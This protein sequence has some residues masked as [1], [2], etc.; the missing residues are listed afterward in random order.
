VRHLLAA[1][2]LLTLV[3][4]RGTQ[5]EAPVKPVGPTAEIKAPLGLPPVPIPVDNPPTA[6]TIALGRVLYFDKKLSGD[7]S[8]ACA[9]CHRPDKG[10]TDNLQFSVGV[11]GKF[12]GRNA[13]TV[14][15]AAYNPEQFWDG[16]AANLELQAEGPIANE[17]EMRLPHK[18][19]VK[20]LNADPEY[21]KLFDKAFGPGE[22]TMEKIR[23]CLA[24]FERT[25]LSGNSAFDRYQ[26]GG[27]KTAMSPAAI[28]GLEL[29]RDKQKTNCVTCHTIDEKYALFTDGKYHNLGVGMN[30]EGELKDL[31]R[32]DIS[33]V[34]TDKGAF[35]T[36]TLRNVALT[37]P[38]MHDGSKKTLR[39]VVDFY[40][41][42]GNSNP[43]RD[44]E[45]RELKLKET[46]RQDLVAFMEALTGEIPK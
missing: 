3:S 15:N 24:S 36:P 28:R 30:D 5:P 8:V 20:K 17:V 11:G 2:I 33:K 41:S 43:Y 16:R 12:G 14:L 22:I 9:S 1:A 38:Y 26:F 27:D 13:P 4:C 45:I 46:E 23:D 39:E 40:V 10:F 44:K 19:A 29:F 34:E 31:G 7:D 6:D 35:R 37:G 21:K 25:M 18:T 42:G 32:Y